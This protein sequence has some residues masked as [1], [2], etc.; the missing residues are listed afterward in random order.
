VARFDNRGRLIEFDITKLEN[1]E[2]ADAFVQAVHRGT[3]QIIQGAFVGETGKWAHSGLLKLLT[4]FRTFSLIAIDKQWNRQA[5]NYGTAAALGILL[6]T[7]TLAIPI[8]MVRAGINSIGR[9]DQDEYLEKRLS[10]LNL[11]RESLNYVALSGLSGDLLDALS[12]VSGF[13]PTGGRTGANKSLVGNVIA[14]AVGK[15]ND[16]WGALQNSKDGTD[17]HGLIAQLPFSRLPWLYPA[18][19]ALRPD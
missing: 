13:E 3:R 5:G 17:I 11:A 6:G 9:P 2:A 4:Q 14:P 8:I 10:P 15:A 19:N 7:M 16:I 12:A 1:R 18:V